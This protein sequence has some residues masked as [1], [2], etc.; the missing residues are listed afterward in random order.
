MAAAELVSVSHTL[1]SNQ[2]V[3]LYEHSRGKSDR[4]EVE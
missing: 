1:N 2:V 3:R 4:L